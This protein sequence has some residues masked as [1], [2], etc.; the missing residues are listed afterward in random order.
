MYML[1]LGRKV[2]ADEELLGAGLEE[3]VELLLHGDLG[4]LRG[5]GGLG[6]LLGGLLSGGLL[7]SHHLLGCFLDHLCVCVYERLL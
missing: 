3:S 6:S 2:L 4:L 1:P 7:D 5:L